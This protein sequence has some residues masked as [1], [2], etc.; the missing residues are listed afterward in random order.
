MAVEMGRLGG[1][2]VRNLEGLFTCYDD[3]YSIIEEMVNQPRKK[4]TDFIQE[5]YRVPIKEHLV[6]ES[7]R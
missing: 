2:G 4:I 3:P 1:W 6:R 5:V 7:R